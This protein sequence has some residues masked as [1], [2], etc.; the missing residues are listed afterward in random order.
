MPEDD[1]VVD[2]RQDAWSALTQML[3]NDLPSLTVV[4]DGKPEGVISR[5][6]ILRLVQ[7]KLTPGLR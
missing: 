6:S 7:R 2:E 3:E 1:P 4:R 5:E